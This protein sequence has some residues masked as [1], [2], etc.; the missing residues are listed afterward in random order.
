MSMAIEQE[1]VIALAIVL[2]E[3]YFLMILYKT[4]Y[5][6]KKTLKK[7]EFFLGVPSCCHYLFLCA[8]VGDSSEIFH[9]SILN[10]CF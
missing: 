7:T 2:R 9:G 6:P 1:N 5:L 3:K 4:D 8:F 10:L